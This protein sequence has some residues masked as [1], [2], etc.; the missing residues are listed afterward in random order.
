M[1]DVAE[2]YVRPY[3]VGVCQRL[4]EAKGDADLRRL[5]GQVN[6]PRDLVA[7]RV[8]LGRIP[9]PTEMPHNQRCRLVYAL[10][11][12]NGLNSAHEHNT[13]GSSARGG[14]GRADVVIFTPDDEPLIV[15]EVKSPPVY[16]PAIDQVSR[17]RSALG[18]PHAV[19]LAPRW[20]P[21][22]TR[23][24]AAQDVMLTNGPEL[25]DLIRR[26]AITQVAA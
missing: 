16:R 6:S 2:L 26:C 18:A 20:N 14:L 7:A 21:L 22:A 25:V 13:P 4:T 9:F 8:H 1:T 24:A 3:F 23:A 5:E 12:M 11:W 19:V 10:A 17:Y 15:V